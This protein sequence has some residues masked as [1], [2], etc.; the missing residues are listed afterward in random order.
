MVSFNYMFYKMKYFAHNTIS[1]GGFRAF[2]FLLGQVCLVAN[3]LLI[4]SKFSWV[5]LFVIKGINRRIL[6]SDMAI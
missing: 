4:Y 6:C 1:F 3:W 5:C 2:H